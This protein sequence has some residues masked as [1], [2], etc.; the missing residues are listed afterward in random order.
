MKK[1]KFKIRYS[2]PKNAFILVALVIAATITVLFLTFLI[3]VNAKEKI[4]ITEFKISTDEFYNN[5][6]YFMTSGPDGNLWFTKTNINKIGRITPKGKVT[7]FVVPGSPGDITLGSDSNLWF[8]EVSENKIVR[9][10]LS[11]NISEFSLPT[12]NGG[13][14]NITSG[15]DGNLWFAEFG[16]N[17]IGRITPNGIITEF[18]IPT[19]GSGPSDITAGP[20]GNL[21]FTEY[22]A[23][24]IGR[25]TPSGQITEFVIPTNNSTPL[26][27]TAG[28]DGNI[29]FTEHN[30][31]YK[32]GRITTNGEITEF[33]IS[34]GDNNSNP[35]YITSA[36]DG[37]LWFTRGNKVGRITANGEITEF[38]APTNDSNPSDITAGPD[39]NVWYTDV[40]AQTIGRV[41][42]VDQR[43]PNMD[44]TL[45]SPF[46][47]G[48]TW[49][50][51]QGYFNN[52]NQSSSGC[53]IGLG[54]DHCRNQL[55]GLDMVPDPQS[56]TDILAPGNGKVTF[57]GRLPEENCIGLRITLD[58]GL[59]MNV[60]HFATW[61]VDIGERVLRGKVLG[62]RSSLHVHL[63]LDDRYRIGTLCPGQERC[64]LPIPFDEQHTLEERSFN[65]DP[66]GETVLLPYPLCDQRKVDCQF[67][68]GFQQYKGT[69]GVSTNVAIP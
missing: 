10:T 2:K 20:D 17:K 55:F 25:I 31:T 12:S 59:N 3:R 34:I 9:F 13:A 47:N 33:I 40:N 67:E 43:G 45:L 28:P 53:H 6:P 37:N 49:T 54:P 18:V 21:W 11:G 27:I 39:G 69:S 60:C 44:D 35:N 30:N 64:F 7:E 56:D 15:R 16:A 52:R 41:N 66:N 63:S 38:L 5:N 26:G 68:V 48:V 46:N 22:Y 51:S 4:T 23:N 65:P 36:P 32:I 62:T 58:N 24:Q 42:L 29:W 8:T 19:S 14:F 1:R 50:V 61:N 57:K